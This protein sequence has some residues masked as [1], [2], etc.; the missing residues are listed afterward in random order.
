M[1]WTAKGGDAMGEAYQ[2]LPTGKQVGAKVITHAQH[3]IF[4]MAEVAGPNRLFRAIL[5][6]VRRLRPPEMVP[7]F[8]REPPRQPERMEARG[9][10]ARIG[11]ERL[12]A[13]RFGRYHGPDAAGSSR[14]EQ[15]RHLL[16]SRSKIELL[17]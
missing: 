10:S 12:Y 15:K 5:E 9:C 17:D 3:V 14:R 13:G 7:G 1:P 16:I 11:N 8:R 4:Q 6:R 2:D